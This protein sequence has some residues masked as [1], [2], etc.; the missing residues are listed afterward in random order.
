M[1]ERGRPRSFDREAALRQAM[2]IFW[3]RGYEGTSLADLMA[4]MNINAPSLYAA[5]GGKEALFRE[6][7]TYYRDTDGSATGEALRQGPTARAAVEAMLMTATTV[8]TLPGKP[9]GCL[10]VLGAT[11]T[12]PSNRPVDVFLHEI[13]LASAQSIRKR[14]LQGIADGELPKETDINQLTAYFTTVLHGMSLQAR[15]GVTQAALQGVVR[16]AMLIWPAPAAVKRVRTR[17]AA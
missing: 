17:S 4:A 6:A 8:L 1:A 16:T 13:R 10:V 5:F 3:E 2:E 11:N 7:V 15:D 9:T 14:L 12:T